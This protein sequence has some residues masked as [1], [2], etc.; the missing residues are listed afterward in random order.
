MAAD[1]AGEQH[2]GLRG[3]EPSAPGSGRAGAGLSCL[4]DAAGEQHRGLRGGG[5]QCP[6]QRACRGGTILSERRSRRP[7]GTGPVAL[8]R[9]L[10]QSGASPQVAQGQLPKRDMAE[11]QDVWLAI[12]G[13]PV[14]PVA[15]AHA[16]FSFVLSWVGRRPCRASAPDQHSLIV[17]G[18][19]FSRSASSG[20]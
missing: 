4:N 13:L 19:D 16:P 15:R 8:L 18:V 7:G 11:A 3:G 20:D 1:A 6:R 10:F 2:R 9:G 5:A 17:A 12:A 14:D